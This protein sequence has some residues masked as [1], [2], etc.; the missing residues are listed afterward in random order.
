MG[1]G[2]MWLRHDA[3]IGFWGLPA[4]GIPFAGLF[5]R[6]RA[7]NDHILARLPVDRGG[8]L[9]FGVSWQESR[10]RSTSSKLRP[11]VIG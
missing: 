1:P 5:I 7:G 8:N 2:L 11:L 3:Q 6:D 4:A 10:S 9:M